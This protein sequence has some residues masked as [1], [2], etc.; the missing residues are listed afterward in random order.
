MQLNFQFTQQR[1]IRIGLLGLALLLCIASL[2]SSWWV[3]HA[4]GKRNTE[5]FSEYQR[6]YPFEAGDFSDAGALE[7]YGLDSEVQVTGWLMVLATLGVAATLLVELLAAAGKNYGMWISLVPTGTAALPSLIA[8]LYTFFTWP[9]AWEAGRWFFDSD[10]LPP[11][12]G[13]AAEF[14]YYGGLGWY[15]AIIGGLGIPA[16]L[17]LYTHI[18]NPD[19]DM[20]QIL[21]ETG[22]Q[23]E[24]AVQVTA[25]RPPPPAYT[26]P[27][28]DVPTYQ[29][30]RAPTTD[31]VPSRRVPIER[32]KD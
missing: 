30:A 26:P 14:T 11:T 20:D 4:E 32:G 16:G 8:I 6:A 12:P 22:V 10:K 28:S 13:V 3:I 5:R 23:A 15:F 9:P 21:K 19:P 2:F 24:P 1:L 25:A 7:G 31:T 18:F 27:A 17:Y 29:P